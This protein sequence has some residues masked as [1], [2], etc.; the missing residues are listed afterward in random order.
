M[1]RPRFVN[2][3][4]AHLGAVHID[5]AQMAYVLQAAN[6][7]LLEKHIAQWLQWNALEE[8]YSVGPGSQM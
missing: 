8:K 7:M 6:I 2:G 5:V 1:D 3:I 4:R